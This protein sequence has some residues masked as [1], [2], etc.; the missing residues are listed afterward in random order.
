MTN[1]RCPVLLGSHPC[2]RPVGHDGEH[3]YL[4][5]SATWPGLPADDPDWNTGPNPPFI[6]GVSVTLTATNS[7][8]EQVAE[9]AQAARGTAVFRADR[10]CLTLTEVR[11]MQYLGRYEAA[12]AEADS[13]KERLEEI[14][15]GIKA[16]ARELFP[17]YSAMV[18]VPNM[19][20]APSLTLS[21][22]TS[23]RIDTAKV[24]AMLTG[25][26]YRALTK[27]S[28]SW[29]LKADKP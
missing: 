6:A 4:E 29:V 7:V 1:S 12:K 27:P 21:Q 23:N 5:E 17:G 14:V 25:E 3:V 16:N 18:L 8:P 13:A 19:P 28:V 10:P 2:T 20:G 26:Q 9:A 22:Q 24:K 11:L 15:N